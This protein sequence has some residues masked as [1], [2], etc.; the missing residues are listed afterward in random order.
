MV[1][2]VAQGE[3]GIGQLRLGGLSR[4]FQLLDPPLDHCRAA[5]HVGLRLAALAAASRTACTG[6]AG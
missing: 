6:L 4:I 2:D 5:L 1:F 3:P